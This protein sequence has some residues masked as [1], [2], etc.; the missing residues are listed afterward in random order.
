MDGLESFALGDLLYENPLAAAADV[1]DFRLEGQ[2]AVSFPAGRMRLE[3]LLDPALGQASNFVFWCPYEFPDHIA[4][5]WDF[6]PIRE[7]GLCMLFFAAKGRNGEALF[8]GRKE[9]PGSGCN[10]PQTPVSRDEG[11]RLTLESGLAP[12]CGI[13]DQY[14]HGDIDAFHVSYFRRKQADERRFHTCNLRK[15]YGFHLVAQ[16]GDPIPSVPDAVGPYRIMLGKRGQDILFAINELPIFQWHDDG[17]SYGKP[18][19]GGYIGFRQMAPLIAEYAN[20]RVY[21]VIS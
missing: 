9:L 15:S 1:A 16:G 7:P 2:A 4:V 10:P 17:E 20:L 6:W 12:R 5:T 3:N 11:E 19:G 13:Y 14:H 8:A 18:L 21:A